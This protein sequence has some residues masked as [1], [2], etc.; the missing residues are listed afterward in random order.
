MSHELRTPLNCIIGFSEV[1]K[2]EMFGPL[3]NAKYSEYVSDIYSSSQ[4]LLAVISDILD[5]SKMEA[6]V[7]LVPEIPKNLPHLLADPLRIKQILINLVSN[8][9]KF[10]PDDGLIRVSAG[11]GGGQ[12][13]I[14]KVADTGVG[15]A[16]EDIPHCLGMFG[17]ARQSQNLAHEGTGLGLALTKSL[18]EQHGGIL[19][20]GSELNVGTTVTLEFPSTRTQ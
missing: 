16:A 18:V 3:K 6:G 11:L 12:A 14:L 1:I 15:I 17:Q 13:I 9:V 4:H 5:F 7:R 20:L 19:T 8:A 2:R 10:T